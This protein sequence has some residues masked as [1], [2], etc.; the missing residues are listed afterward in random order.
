[1]ATRGYVVENGRIAVE[2]AA[3]ALL[4]DPRVKSA[5]LGR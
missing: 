1:L 2:G 3:S 5:Y 4:D